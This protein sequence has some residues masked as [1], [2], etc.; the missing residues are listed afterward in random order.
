MLI[1]V[2]S[3]CHLNCVPF[4]LN[5]VNKPLMLSVVKLNVIT[6]SV[7]T[8]NAIILNVVMLSFLAP[9]A[10]LDQWM[11]MA[12]S[13]LRGFS[14]KNIEKHFVDGTSYYNTCL[15]TI[16]FKQGSEL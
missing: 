4:M 12:F 16:F 6:P 2:Y 13:S 5:V 15:L 14:P 8:L 11:S 3:E 7:I 10:R 9:V 1:V